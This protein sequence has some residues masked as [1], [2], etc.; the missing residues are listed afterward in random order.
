MIGI[1]TDNYNTDGQGGLPQTPYL[2]LCASF[3][4][5]F[6]MNAY[7]Y[8]AYPNAFRIT[9]KCVLCHFSVGPQ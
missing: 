2:R 8:T 7:T 5:C 1:P 6:I 4:V 3:Y 9:D